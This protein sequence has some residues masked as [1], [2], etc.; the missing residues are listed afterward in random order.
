[1]DKDTVIIRELRPEELDAVRDLG[2]RAFSLPMGLSM[3]ATVSPQGLVA[4][5]ATGTIVGVLTLRTASVGDRKLG[6]LDWGAVDPQHQSKGIGKALYDQALVW[7]RQRGC[8]KAVTTGVDGYNSA[9][10]NPTHSRGLCYWPVSQ[11][12]REFGWRWL[13]LLFVIPHVIGIG[14]FILQAPLNEQKQPETPATSG[15]GALIGVTLFLGFFLLPLSRV[16][17]VLWRGMV[18]SDLLV[19]L[20]PLAVL[21]GVGIIATYMGI[22]AMAHWLAARALRL[23]ITFRLWDTGLIMATFLAAAFSAFVPGLGSSCYARQTRF[24]YSRARPAMGKIML[25]GVAASL[26][27]LIVFTVFT[28]CTG[29]DSGTLG[30]ITMLGRYVGVSFGIT[31]TLFFFAPFQALPAG[32]LWRWRRAVWF[33]TFACFLGIWLVLPRIL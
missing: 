22:R 27:L 14:T 5:D 28:V 13:K 20:N 23:P 16:R 10:W 18:V 7:F 33:V 30:E 21:V 11:Q 32:H 25:A 3:A 2:K 15:I 19:P 31:D 1:M 17:A 24:N 4:E 9:V 8:D 6:I 12:I 29:M 26:A